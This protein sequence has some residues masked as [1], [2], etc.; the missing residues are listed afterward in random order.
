MI[1]HRGKKWKNVV[2]A[3]NFELNLYLQKEEEDILG[4]MTKEMELF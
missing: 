2:L 1:L 4:D 3:T